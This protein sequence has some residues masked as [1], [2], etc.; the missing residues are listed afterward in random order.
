MA[1]EEDVILKV[2][3]IG[4]LKDMRVEGEYVRRRHSAESQG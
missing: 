4:T 2:I 1:E 3:N